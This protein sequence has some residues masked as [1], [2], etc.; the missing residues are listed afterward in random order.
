MKANRHI[1]DMIGMELRHMEVLT[2]F[3]A[4]QKRKL[5][6]DLFV[7]VDYFEASNSRLCA[8]V[9]SKMLSDELM[10]ITNSKNLEFLGCT[11]GQH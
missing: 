8:N 2:I 7:Y 4:L 11:V 6:D 10:T 9:T 5:L 3:Q 1:I